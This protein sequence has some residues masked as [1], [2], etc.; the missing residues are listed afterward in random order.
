MLFRN[1][2]LEELLERVAEALERIAD[3]MEADR[4][5]LPP[6]LASREEREEE[7]P[8]VSLRPIDGTPFERFFAARKM[9]VRG[10]RNP[11]D[12]E[13]LEF[14]AR[15]LGRRYAHLH[16][17]YKKIKRS[18]ISGKGFTLK[19]DPSNPNQLSA[20]VEFAAALYRRGLL[21]HYSYKRSPFF[22]LSLQPASD[23]RA[24]NFLTGGWLELYV[25]QTMTALLTELKASN[26]VTYSYLHNVEIGERDRV[27]FELDLLFKINHEYFWIETKT[28]EYEPYIPRYA[29]LAKK[30][31]L[32]KDHA[33]IVATEL[34]SEDAL[35]LNSIFDLTLVPLGEFRD[36]M[37]EVLCRRL[38][39]KVPGG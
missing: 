20:M 28:A 27:D 39:L 25:K 3:L 24:I 32:D 16:Q 5:A 21:A 33:F 37:K 6:V 14:L 26:S 10:V 22:L 4:G 34:T 38:D 23:P 8:K 35:R 12:D 29:E 30:L 17:L 13:M 9:P 31:S 19:L 2:R 1:R 18:L 7:T 36:T 11:E 15:F